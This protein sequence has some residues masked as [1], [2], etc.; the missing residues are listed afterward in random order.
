M[1]RPHNTRVVLLILAL[2][3]CSSGCGFLDG[4]PSG[5]P[6]VPPGEPNVI[7][8]NPSDWY[9]LYSAG[10]PEHPSSSSEGAW[11]FAF[12]TQP[13]HV[14]YVQTPFQTTETPTSLTIT[15]RV[16]SSAPQ[17]VVTDPTDIPPATFRLMIEQ[18]GDDLT[19]PNG[20]WW[21]DDFLYD[22]GSEDNQTLSVVVP[23]TS[24]NWSNVD[25]R[26][27]ANA[28]AAA[29][30]NVG[31][32]GVTF[33]GQYFAGHGAALSSGTAQFVLIDYHVN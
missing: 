8:L 11:S 22:L 17:Y 4:G 29:L 25:G 33:G 6:A 19:N 21:A 18:Q 12:P 16:D 15:F 23:L 27:D 7:S 2:A 14:N 1:P 3:T 13:N 32:V 10:I 26:H 24:D 30:Q 28:F 31:W 9:I 20:R 5:P